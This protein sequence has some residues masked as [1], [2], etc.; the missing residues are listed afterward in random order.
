MTAPYLSFDELLQRV[1]PPDRSAF[2]R[3]LT[4]DDELFRPLF[5]KEM[6]MFRN[7]W[8]LAL[9]ASLVLVCPVRAEKVNL[10]PEQLRRTATHVVTGQVTAVYARTETEGDWKYTRYVAE[11]R[12]GECEK[13]DG[14][15]KGDLVYVRYWRRSWVG[16]GPVPPSTAGHR[17]LPRE[18]DSIR[19]YLAR[20]A[21]DGF[22]PNNKDG[23]FN[24]IGANGFE[25]L[26]PA[27][28]K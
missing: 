13:G 27:A 25:P 3:L 24:V 18:G 14:I 16:K 21:Y 17:G 11:V 8:F 23:G 2:Q 12:V 20:N 5:T 4:S 1:D 19:A 9:A 7:L 6:H 26:K 15:K 22:D 10:S 28:G